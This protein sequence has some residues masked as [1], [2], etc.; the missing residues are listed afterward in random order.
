MKNSRLGS[1]RRK[2][3]SGGLQGHTRGPRSGTRRGAR[4][5]PRG[6]PQP[7]RASLRVGL[8][9]LMGRN[10]GIANTR[11]PSNDNSFHNSNDQDATFTFQLE[12]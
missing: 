1:L 6:V 12:R 11:G 2:Q 10:P 7:P 4:S 8:L 5:L 9:R 3:A